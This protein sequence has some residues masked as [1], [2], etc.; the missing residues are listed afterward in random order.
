MPAS[1]T[2]RQTKRFWGLFSLARWTVS[3]GGVS[4]HLF[5][6]RI[7]CAS[8]GHSCLPSSP[9]VTIDFC[10][11]TEYMQC[12]HLQPGSDSC[13]AL[14]WTSDFRNK[15]Q[16]PGPQFEIAYYFPREL[17]VA[18]F[19]LTLDGVRGW[20]LRRGSEVWTGSLCTDSEW[21]RWV[22]DQKL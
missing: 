14:C 15:F 13:P 12:G 8:G 9:H 11:G 18:R 10:L 1:W 7:V 17:G 2:K 5:F 20:L 22:N 6:L 19:K 3:S 16:W 4:W 21:T